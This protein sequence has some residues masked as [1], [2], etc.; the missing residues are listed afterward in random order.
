MPTPAFGFRFAF[1][2]DLAFKFL[3]GDAEQQNRFAPATNGRWR[4]A[5]TFDFL[6]VK[7]VSSLDELEVEGIVGSGQANLDSYGDLV[8]FPLSEVDSKKLADASIESPD[9]PLLVCINLTLSP[10]AY[11]FEPHYLGVLRTITRMA[12]AL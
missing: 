7:P 3:R 6:E 2:R 11:Q 4:V 1:S 9:Q 12:E 10:A 8:V 5:G